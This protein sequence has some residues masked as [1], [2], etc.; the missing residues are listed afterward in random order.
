MTS[1]YLQYVD[2]GVKR[3]AGFCRRLGLAAVAGATLLSTPMATSPSTAAAMSTI[4]SEPIRCWWKTDK[5]AVH[6]GE[7][8]VLAL[9]CSVIE[10]GR[11]TV[12]PNLEQLDPGAIRLA[13]FEVLEG[14]RHED[15]KAGMWRYFQYEYKLRL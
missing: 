11:V 15:I 2:A 13:P 3:T 4:E 9:T 10:T 8:F 14:V 7:R 6:V 5:T 12:V 1:T